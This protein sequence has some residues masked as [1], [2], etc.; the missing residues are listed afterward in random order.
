LVSPGGAVIDSA[1]IEKRTKPIN[2]IPE[3]YTVRTGLSIIE[4]IIIETINT[5]S[6]V[7]KNG[8]YTR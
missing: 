7:L 3:I 2:L 6:E 4:T 5:E 1:K 8:Y